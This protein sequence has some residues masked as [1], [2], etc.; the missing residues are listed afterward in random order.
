MALRVTQ[1]NGEGKLRQ[2]IIPKSKIHFG[3]LS[4][5]NNL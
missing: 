1:G 4:K 5:G 3:G 2:K